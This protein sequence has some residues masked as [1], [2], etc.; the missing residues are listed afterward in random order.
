MTTLRE[1][2]KTPSS[3]SAIIMQT[4]MSILTLTNLAYMYSQHAA[5]NRR[6]Q[7]R[8]AVSLVSGKKEPFHSQFGQWEGGGRAIAETQGG[9]GWSVAG[10]GDDDEWR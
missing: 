8:Y 10:S 7:V 2:P 9:S 5:S 4:S 1:L 6:A 3:V